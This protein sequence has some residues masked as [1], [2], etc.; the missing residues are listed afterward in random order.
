MKRVNVEIMR[1]PTPQPSSKLYFNSITKIEQQPIVAKSDLHL[2]KD[3]K[4]YNI[5]IDGLNW[6]VCNKMAKLKPADF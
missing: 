3:L 2:Y 5:L 4:Y 6:G 1:G